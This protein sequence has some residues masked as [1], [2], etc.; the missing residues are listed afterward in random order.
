MS[1]ERIGIYTIGHGDLTAD[2]FVGLLKKHG[3]TLVVD[4]RSVPYSRRAVYGNYGSLE[5]LLVKYGIDSRYM[6]IALGGKPSDPALLDETG[7]PDFERM[8][9]APAFLAGIDELAQEPKKDTKSPK[10]PKPPKP[11]TS[12]QLDL[13]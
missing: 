5:P 6:G 13:F 2:E 11:K 9:R 10:S 4:A 8:A 1:E 7:A 12:E 3:I